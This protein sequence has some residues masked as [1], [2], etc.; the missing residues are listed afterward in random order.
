MLS[1]K[2]RF[3]VWTLVLVLLFLYFLTTSI[4]LLP[5]R[6]DIDDIVINMVCGLASILSMIGLFL[7]RTGGADCRF[8]GAI[9]QLLAM[10]GPIKLRRVW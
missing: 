9:H 4:Q 3:A 7:S 5:L 6:H 1:G 2:T 8:T 10:Y